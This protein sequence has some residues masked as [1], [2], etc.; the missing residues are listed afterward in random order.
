[1]GC[2][3]TITADRF[4]KQGSQVGRVV[5]VIFHYDT[6][7]RLR[8]RILRDDMEAPWETLIMLEDERI[9]RASECQYSPAP[10]EPRHG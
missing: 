3:E 6:S 2:V 10:E 5:V 7:Q 8:G 4:P 9:V 1:M